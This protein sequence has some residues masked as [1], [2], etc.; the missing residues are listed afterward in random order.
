LAGEGTLTYDDLRRIAGFPLDGKRPDQT[1]SD[2]PEQT[3]LLDL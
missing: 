3:S 1:G 2:D